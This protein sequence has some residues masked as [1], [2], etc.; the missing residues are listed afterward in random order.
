MLWNF[1]VMETRVTT[2]HKKG[3]ESRTQIE[4][5]LN[6]FLAWLF[7]AI[8]KHIQKMN[9]ERYWYSLIR[10]IFTLLA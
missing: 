10:K 3:L 7:E 2:E 4:Y 8:N 9:F 6:L 1:V 5:K